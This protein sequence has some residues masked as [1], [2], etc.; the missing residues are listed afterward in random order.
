METKR[1]KVYVEVEVTH[2]TDGT[3]R[4]NLIRF[5]NGERYE[6]DRVI[7]RC[8]AASTKWAERAFAIRFRFAVIRHS[9]S[10][11]K[12]ASGLSKRKRIKGGRIIETLITLGY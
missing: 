9:C 11:R 5:E 4:P 3:A 6:V 2:R 8:R 7:Q 10:M 1:R 12:T